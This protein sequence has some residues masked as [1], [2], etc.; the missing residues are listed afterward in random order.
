LEPLTARCGRSLVSLH[1]AM[2]LLKSDA[3]I[4]LGNSHAVHDVL[5][6]FGLH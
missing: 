3:S 1:D 5:E 2:T 6:M 4:R